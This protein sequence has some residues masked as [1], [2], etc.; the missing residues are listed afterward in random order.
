MNEKFDPFA[1][2][3]KAYAINPNLTLVE[4]CLKTA[5]VLEYPEL[6]ISKYI[7]K[8][9]E[10]GN[11]LKNSIGKIENPTYKISMLNEHLFEHNGRGRCEWTGTGWRRHASRGQ[12]AWAQSG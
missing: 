2:E 4:K 6:D 1:S 10:I 5:Q 7:E 3:W 12:H 9:N 8:L 11:S